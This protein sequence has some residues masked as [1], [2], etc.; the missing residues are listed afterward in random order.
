MSLFNDGVPRCS[1]DGCYGDGIC[2]DIVTLKVYCMQHA[3]PDKQLD[4]KTPAP[5]EKDS[6]DESDKIRAHGMGCRLE[7]KA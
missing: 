4:N 3:F 5:P 1:V 6:W 2:T 7:K